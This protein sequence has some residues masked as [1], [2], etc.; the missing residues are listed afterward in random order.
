M[1]VYFSTSITQGRDGDT[2]LN[3]TKLLGPCNLIKEICYTGKYFN[4]GSEATD[5]IKGN[6]AVCWLWRW[7]DL[8]WLR[9]SREGFVNTIPHELYQRLIGI[10][11]LSN[12]DN[13]LVIGRKLSALAQ[14]WISF[15]SVSFLL[16]QVTGAA[17][18]MNYAFLTPSVCL[19]LD[20]C[21]YPPPN[22]C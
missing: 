19:Q 11:L 16:L 2:N 20:H 7:F 22:F 13:I 17:R 14:T 3:K 9:D 15:P 4:I 12:L 10:S 1:P 8:N 5:Y 6:H 21:H 18:L